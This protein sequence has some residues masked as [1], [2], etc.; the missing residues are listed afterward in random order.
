MIV[1]ISTHTRVREGWQPRKRNGRPERA[2]Y[3]HILMRYRAYSAAGAAERR[4]RTAAG[5]PLVGFAQTQMPMIMWRASL[6]R[7]C[8]NA[9][10]SHINWL[11]TQYTDTYIVVFLWRTW[12]LRDRYLFRFR[13]INFLVISCNWFRY[14]SRIILIVDSYLEEIMTNFDLSKNNINIVNYV[15]DENGTKKKI[16]VSS[17][18]LLQ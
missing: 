13:T 8:E 10:W 9:M 18:S 2:V 3:L 6:M 14:S 11:P 12:S 16:L 4:A 5:N 17:A 7:S 15:S 1:N